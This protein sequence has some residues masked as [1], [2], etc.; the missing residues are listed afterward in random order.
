MVALVLDTDL[1]MGAPGSDID[2]GFALALAVADPDIDLIAVTTVNGNTDVDTATI[3]TGELLRRL[4]R[5]GIPVHRGA[6]LPLLRPKARPRPPTPDV[7]DPDFRGTT[8][9]PAAAAL[10]RLI[11]DNPH[12][13]T[14]AAVGPLTNIALALRLDPGIAELVREVVVMGGVFL[15]QTNRRDMPGEFN[16]WVDPEAAQIVV[17]SGVPLRFVGLDVTLRVRLSTA[18]AQA[19]EDSD[20]PFARF[21]GQHTRAWIAHQAEA[22]PGSEVDR[23]S[24]A[25]HDPLAV[26][27]VTH[28]ELLQWAPAHVAFATGSERTRGIAVADLLDSSTP[29]EPNCRIATDVD[30]EAFRAHFISRI[31]SIR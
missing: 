3:L 7:A 18:D 17:G 14:I 4:D 19:L 8:L 2:D 16:V 10:V 29:P 9:E 26:A 6:E 15:G 24:C 30:A 1:A 25:M 13:I 27:A 21:A 31:Q 11:R 22:H 20:S 23:D 28:P 5:Q 12:Q